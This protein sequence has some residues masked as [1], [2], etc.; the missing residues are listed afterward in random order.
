LPPELIDRAKRTADIRTARGF[1][2]V[3]CFF[4]ANVAPTDNPLVRKAINHAVD[5][6]AIVK[7]I[8]GGHA[9]AA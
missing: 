6:D 4:N 8:L 2:R 9:Y 5:V 7:N 1:R 3:F